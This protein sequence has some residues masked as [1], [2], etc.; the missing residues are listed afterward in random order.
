VPLKLISAYLSNCASVTFSLICLSFLVGALCGG[1]YTRVDSEH[2]LVPCI[3]VVAIG[4]VLTCR[5]RSN[6]TGAIQR[7]SRATD[8]ISGSLAGRPD[9]EETK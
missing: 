8:A 7:T 6:A 9:Q 1:R 2:A 3:A 4:F 5:A